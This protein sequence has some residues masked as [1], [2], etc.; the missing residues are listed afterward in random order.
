M[1]RTCFPSRSEVDRA[2]RVP[3]SVRQDTNSFSGTAYDLIVPLGGCDVGPATIL[4]DLILQQGAGA[5]I[6][7]TTIGRDLLANRFTESCG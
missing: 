6:S 7:D 1:P 4:H 2:S 3:S 5:N